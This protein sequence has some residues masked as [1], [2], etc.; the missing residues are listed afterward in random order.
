MPSTTSSRP[1][2]ATST[3][4][5][6]RSKSDT[7]V[8]QALSCGD[9]IFV[10]S[11]TLVS[12]YDHT[13]RSAVQHCDPGTRNAPLAYYQNIIEELQQIS[14]KRETL[15]HK[16]QKLGQRETALLHALANTHSTTTDTET[17]FSNNNADEL[18][19][20]SQFSFPIPTSTSTVHIPKPTSA[21]KLPRRSTA[22]A[23]PPLSR[24]ISAPPQSTPPGSKRRT[25][26]RAPLADKTQLSLETFD[27]TP[28]YIAADMS[29]SPTKSD[30]S[31]SSASGTADLPGTVK[32]KSSKTGTPK[33]K[34]GLSTARLRVRCNEPVFV[35]TK[36]GD[37]DGDVRAGGL[38]RREMRTP[39]TPKVSQGVAEAGAVNMPVQDDVT[40]GSKDGMGNG[41]R[42]YV[43]PYTVLRKK[44]QF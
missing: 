3:G 20:L 23:K 14:E 13:S 36:L 24:P 35:P 40:R 8:P 26:D 18:I 4:N 10:A 38:G 19:Q 31:V 11:D 5:H 32:S 42:G 33:I 1:Q 25:T 17:T 30:T 43:V 9:S 41:E 34:G 15:L 27:S 37:D 28:F 12:L 16:L 21:F 6:T 2:V 29:A 39:R 44:W 7:V 22:S